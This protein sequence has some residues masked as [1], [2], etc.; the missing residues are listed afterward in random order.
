MRIL[1]AGDKA[2][3]DVPRLLSRAFEQLG[4]AV[5]VFYLNQPSWED[6]WGWRLRRFPG[7][8]RRIGDAL[9]EQYLRSVNN[10]WLDWVLE[11]K[12]DIVV[13]INGVQL[14]PEAVSRTRETLRIPVVNWVLDDP[15]RAQEARFLEAYPLYQTL[16]TCCPAWLEFAKFWGCHVAYLPLAID[17]DVYTPLE[18]IR[19][20]GTTGYDTD[21]VFVGTILANDPSSY[22]RAS[23]AAALARQ[24]HKISLYARGARHFVPL[25]SGLGDATIVEEMP[26]TEDVNKIYNRAKIVL[27]MHNIFNQHVVALR[28]FEA[29]A[30][31]AFQLTTH[32]DELAPLF[33][34]GLIQT[35]RSQGELTSKVRRFLAQP[36][37]RNRLGTEAALHV[38]GHHTYRHRAKEILE[39]A[40]S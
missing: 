34:G 15:S 18:D 24:G 10:R 33:P 36:D 5:S 27:N 25:L 28:V 11:V 16:F 37:E 20:L 22:F 13:V 7:R 4:H 1:V 26:S 31:G 32:Q 8:F 29:A 6:R 39:T 3:A 12:P 21:V 19:K 38:R 30:A 40:L 23:M 35:Y 9:R 14:L 2:P 17:P